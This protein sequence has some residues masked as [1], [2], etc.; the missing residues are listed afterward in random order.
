MK[1]TKQQ[2]R[3]CV[4]NSKNK[5][6]MESKHIKYFSKSSNFREMQIKMKIDTTSKPHEWLTF[7]NLTKPGCLG[8]SVD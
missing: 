4:N 2:R 3:K 7:K 6:W 5:I 8:G 1:K